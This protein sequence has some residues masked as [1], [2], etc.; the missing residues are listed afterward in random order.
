MAGHR[1]PL[2][3]TLLKQIFDNANWEGTTEVTQNNESPKNV[4]KW[5][6][7]N[8][9]NRKLFQS[10]L[11]SLEDENRFKALSD[12]ENEMERI[13]IPPEPSIWEPESE[14]STDSSEGRVRTQIGGRK[15]KRVKTKNKDGKCKECM[16]DC[17]T[18]GTDNEFFHP[19]RSEKQANAMANESS[20]ETDSRLSD[21]KDEEPAKVLTI[22]P[23]GFNHHTANQA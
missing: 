17:L 22:E 15:K 10:E 8:Q 11:F 7:A 20:N 23:R 9:T 6:K 2:E 21:L 18:D 14:N 13:S 12:S 4:R 5:T 16:S 3:Q 1:H 19:K